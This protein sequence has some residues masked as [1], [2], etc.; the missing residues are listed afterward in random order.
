M[1]KTLLTLSVSLISGL[2]LA[3]SALAASDTGKCTPGT[4]M[5]VRYGQRGPAVQNLQNCLVAGGFFNKNLATGYFGFLTKVAI[6]QFYQSTLG[7]D[8]TDSL[9]PKGIAR[10][11]QML[12]SGSSP[13]GASTGASGVAAFTSSADY[14]AYLQKAGVLRNSSYNMGG[15]MMR[16][17][18]AESL[19]APAPTPM[20]AG[21][22]SIANSTAAAADRVSETNVQVA[23]IDEPDI[24]KTDGQNL[25]YVPEQNY[26]RMMGGITPP[27][28]LAVPMADTSGPSAVSASAI[29][30]PIRPGYY[31]N[32]AITR[33]IQALPASSLTEIGKIDQTG[34]LLLVK[35]KKI[36]LVLLTFHT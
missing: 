4:L 27:M 29:A 2:L 35:D 9:G 22:P 12:G 32:P 10:L 23:G 26:Y 5:G 31:P 18:S 33:V 15:G 28:P 11:K 16:T 3:N 6:K 19:P 14:Q 21:A 34:D 13:A 20:T 7:I 30:M 17:L 24:L 8:F 36:L 25:Y 1:K